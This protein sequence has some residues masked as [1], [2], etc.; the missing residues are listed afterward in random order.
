MR[1]PDPGIQPRVHDQ[2]TPWGP[3]LA[4][5][6]PV[7]SRLGQLRQ[8]LVPVAAGI[9]RR[10]QLPQRNAEAPGNA[11][12]SSCI[13][14]SSA[15]STIAVQSPAYCPEVRIARSASAHRFS[16]RTN[17]PHTVTNASG[18]LRRSTPRTKSPCSRILVANR[19]RV[20]SP[21]TMPNPA[22]QP[23]WSRAIASMTRALSGAFLPLVSMNC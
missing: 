15:R 7:R 10:I 13:D 9:E 8:L 23:E 6:K 16:V 20:L 17:T 3:V 21:E 18:V 22:T 11:H 1:G 19:V 2:L 14:V 12:P 5:L 4:Q